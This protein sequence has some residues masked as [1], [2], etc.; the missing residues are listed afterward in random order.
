[1]ASGKDDCECDTGEAIRRF[2]DRMRDDHHDLKLGQSDAKGIL[3]V[4]VDYLKEL[5]P[6]VDKLESTGAGNTNPKFDFYLRVATI[7]AV[8]I[9][10]IYAKGGF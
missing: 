1:M 9:A 5:G 7:L 3:R 4:I 8:G 10:A 6:K 2:S